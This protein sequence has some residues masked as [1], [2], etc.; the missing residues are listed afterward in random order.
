MV[1]STG[2]RE[3]LQPRLH[4]RRKSPF[5]SICDPL[6]IVSVEQNVRLSLLKSRTAVSRTSLVPRPA[7]FTRKNTFS[8]M[9]AMFRGNLV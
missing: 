8:E 5:H 2:P 7:W 6:G 4:G 9:T 1:Y 3:G